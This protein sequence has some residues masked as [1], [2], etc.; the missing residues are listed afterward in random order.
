M[1]IRLLRMKKTLCV[2]LFVMLLSAVGM[3]NAIA[4]SFTMGNLNYSINADGAT[5]TLTGHVDG[6]NATGTLTIPASVIYNTF[7]YPVTAIEN[8]AFDGCT[9]LTGDLYIGNHVETIGDEAFYGCSGFTGDLH[10]GNSVT[11]VGNYAFYGCTGFSGELIIAHELASVGVS[12][13]YSCSNLMGSAS[14]V[15]TG[16]I[17]SNAFR[18]CTGITSVTIGDAV[19]SVPTYV[20]Y[21]CSNLTTVTIGEGVTSVGGYCFWNCPAITTVNF[22]ATNCT[23]M[24]TTISSRRYSVF[25]SGSSSGGTTPIVY[26]NIGENVTYIPRT[27]FNNS[28][29]LTGVYFGGTIAQ[30]CGITFD[31]TPLFDGHNLY[32]NNALVTSLTIPQGV[33]AISN[34]AFYGCTSISSLNISNSV[35]SIGTSAFYG[36]S[37]LNTATISNSVTTINSNTFYG[38]SSLTSVTIPNSVT[39]IGNSAFYGCNSLISLTIPNSVTSIG[40]SAFYGCN[41]LISLTIPNSVTSIGA[42]AFYGCSGLTSLT[43]GNSVTT[44]DNYA[45]YNCSN[46]TGNLTIPNSVIEIGWAAFYNCSGLSSVTLGSSVESIITEAFYNCTGLTAVYYS[47]TIAQWCGINFMSGNS[48][49]LYYGHNLYLNGALVT[50]LTIPEGTTAIPNNAFG[51]GT[52]INTVNIP[53][54]VTSIGESA[55]SGCAGLAVHYSGTIAQWC[56]ITFNNSYSNPLKNGYLYIDDA[57]VTN[58]VIPYGVTAINPYAFYYCTGI[59]G[60][61]T[62]PNS[63]NTIGDYAFQGCTG[64]TGSLTIPNSVTT[65]DA[66]AFE[67]CS[68][69]TGS[70]TLGTNLYSLTYSSFENCTGF[71]TMNYNATDCYFNGYLNFVPFSGM[72]SLTELNIGSNVQSLAHIKFNGCGSVTSINVLAGAPPAITSFTTT[73]EGMSASIPVIVPCGTLSAYQ[74]ATGWS[75]FTN[76]QEDCGNNDPLTYS[77]N[78][79]GVSVTVTGHVDGTSA[80]GTLIIPET[81]TIN[82]VTYAVTAIGSYAFYHCTGLTGDLIIP[83]SV[84]SI[85]NQA[86]NGCTGFTGTLTIPSSVTSIGNS[87]FNGCTG[88]TGDLTIGNSVTTIGQYVFYNCSGFTGTLTIGNALASIGDQAFSNCTGFSEVHFNAINC[89]VTVSS[90]GGKYPFQNCGGILSIGE[91]VESISDYMFFRSGF[92]GLLTIPNSVTTIG[93]YAFYS[94]SGFT[95]LTIGSSVTAIN[96]YAF[97]GCNGLTSIQTLAV[98]PPILEYVFSNVDHSIPLTV[99]CGTL[100]AYQGTSGWSEFT[101]IQEDCD[102]LTYSINDD[103]VSVTVTGHVDGTAATGTLTIPETKTIDGVTYAVTK[104]G[105]NAFRN[106]SGLTGDLIIPNSV[107]SIGNYAFMNCTGLT[108]SLVIPNSVISIGGFAFM[109]CIGFTGNLILGNSVSYIGARAFGFQNTGNFTGSLVLPDSVIEIGNGA[110]WNCS[111]LTGNLTIPTSVTSLSSAFGGCT[112]FTS[113]TLLWDIPI[114]GS[115][116]NINYDIPVTV[117]C[118]S[119]SLYQYAPSWNNFT[120]YQEDCSNMFVV[121]ATANPIEG[122]N[123]IFGMEGETLF[124]DS[125]EGYTVGN[126]IASEAITAGYDWWNTWDSNPGG[127]KDGIIAEYDG[128]KCGHFT[129]GNDQLLLLGDKENGV[130]DLEFDILVPD[131]KNA[132][133]SLLHQFDNGTAYE[134]MSCHLHVS[135]N[136]YGDPTPGVG[137]I[138]IN[139]NNFCEAYIPCVYDSWMHFRVHVDIDADIARFFFTNSGE[140]EIFLCQWQWSRGRQEDGNGTLAAVDFWPPKDAETSE[141]YVDNISLKQYV[142]EPAGGNLAQTNLHHFA[143]DSDCTLTA[144]ANPGY[145][146][147]NWT[148]NGTTVSTNPTYSFTVTEDAAFVANFNIHNEEDVPVGAIDGVFSVSDSTQ[149]YFSQGNLQYIGSAETHY[150][151]FADNQWDCLGITTGQNNAS[152]NVD[153]DLFGWGTSGYDHGAVCY[154]PWSTITNNGNYYVYGNY[155]YNLY[156][157]TG[158]AEWGYNAISNG[159]NT[160]ND[161]R[162]L[163][164]DEW[165]YVFN[166]R[167]A[168]TVNGVENA[169]Y[170][171]GT[172]D[173][174]FGIILFPNVYVHPDGVAQPTG[175]NSVGGANENNYSATDFALMEANGVV[176]L[177]AA[178]YRGNT[179][180]NRVGST[181]AYWSSSY[182]NSQ[183]AKGMNFENNTSLDPQYNHYRYFGLSVR[184]VHSTQS[185]STSYTIEAMPNPAEG[186]TVM[187][188]G[189]F[190]LGAICTLTATANEGYIFMNWTEN[191]TVV[192]TNANYS[193]TVTGDRNLVANFSQNGGYHFITSGTWSNAANWSGG[194]LPGANDAVSIDA[195][196]TLNIN[197]EVASLTVTTGQTLT[198]QSGKTMT[199][200]G[201]LTNTATMGL[202]IEDG[203]Q[204]VNASINVA[205]TM[206]K[207]ISAHDGASTGWYTIASPM[208][209][210]VIAGSNFL[211]P[212]YDLYRFNETNLTDEE[213]ENYKANLADFTTFENGRGYLY[214]NGNDFTSTFTGILNASA[215]TYSLTCTNRPDDP[216]SGFNLIGNPFPHNIY[217]GASGSID[218]ANL[219]SGYY[220]LDNE[221][222]WQ[223]HSFDDAILPGQGILVRAT[224]ATNLTISKTNAA[225]GAESGQG[226]SLTDRMEIRVSGERGEDCCFVYFGQG[227]GLEKMEH[228]SETAP[229]LSILT[230]DRDYAIAHLNKP[231]EPLKLLFASKQADVYTLTVKCGNCNFDYLHLIDKETGADVDLLQQSSYSFRAADNEYGARFVIVF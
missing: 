55:F 107:T 1:R 144:I 63:L 80:T 195:N 42:A 149:V 224:A 148:K 204:L 227:N 7:N 54:S 52:C 71:T 142:D 10:L 39:S 91:N 16:T 85:S 116:G 161:W 147:V 128:K 60:T 81:T 57:L 84:I 165:G 95:S 90:Y 79:D 201:T 101:N 15:L 28:P 162:T 49:P 44:I 24:E 11:A 3:T 125:F 130:Y 35:T 217:K 223:V 8:N 111:G 110:F 131:G 154:Q 119:M 97:Y 191:G 23:S 187:G 199:V 109:N 231:K 34:N 134:A 87:A 29:N 13:F 211:T 135:N 105:N 164:N 205:A 102:L 98:V 83:N 46:L 179:T 127:E 94:C 174:M 75:S 48:N 30:W 108:G 182:Y 218:N 96:E 173:G 157:Q 99:P 153:R 176:F 67:G 126:T 22:N 25:N 228:L 177:P 213:W 66:N 138:T 133:F 122:G 47:G 132:Y 206:E 104:I 214:A 118:G 20:F 61:L 62:L 185:A 189:T 230:E 37:S 14:V 169:R 59:T 171:K 194:R 168:S 53:N 4:Q 129:F 76:I 152:E 45:F 141:Y 92:N 145:T 193:F 160:G 197:A 150:W 172:V 74:S 114:S 124:S 64:F 136:Y 6:Q 156:D 208:N 143:P 26:L 77:I 139:S 2:V 43:L 65:I 21:G 120:N 178:G 112:G 50:N 155:D 32:I 212:N 88:F 198:L 68:G 27:A 140:E 72:T 192:S 5:V 121:S 103:G 196:C 117:P 158:Q 69:F 12:A 86:F 40:N 225:A 113:L 167:T 17:G 89:S 210:M 73:F 36:C 82:G 215:V 207:V 188:E 70:L 219:A 78:D 163:T 137:T 200:T 146:F 33:T 93:Q 220:T 190:E 9:G 181:C 221:G 41:S 209:G 170:A 151:K 166:T 184:L 100:D 31:S 203:A 180:V 159:G 186:G 115:V 222:T 38:C 202:V 229:S 123:V 51:G 18:N 183:C 175:I 19:T 216:L 106:Y 226:M 58:L 56:G